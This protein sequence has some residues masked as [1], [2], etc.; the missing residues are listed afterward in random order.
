MM[1]ANKWG[2]V[3]NIT[4]ILGKEGGGRPWF[5]MAKAAEVAMMKTLSM[6]KYL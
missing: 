5:N 6:T 4:S 3:I 1:R 2:R